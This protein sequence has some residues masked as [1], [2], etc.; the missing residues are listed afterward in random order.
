[1]KQYVGDEIRRIMADMPDDRI[2][3][4]RDAHPEHGIT[5]YEARWWGFL[6]FARSDSYDGDQ[7]TTP[8]GGTSET[9]TQ[10]FIDYVLQDRDGR[11]RHGLKERSWPGAA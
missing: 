11:K 6:M 4:L 1:M 5:E 10:R 2:E 7:Y 9:L 3:A 8:V